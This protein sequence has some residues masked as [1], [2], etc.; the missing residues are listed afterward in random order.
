MNA[1]LTSSVRI[2][3]AASPASVLR[4][5]A[6]E[7]REAGHNII[8]LASGNLDFAT[9]EH[10]LDAAHEAALKGDTR[11]TE[12]DG[13][14]ALKEAVRASLARHNGLDYQSDEIIISTGSTQALFNAFL[15]TLVVG[16][17]VV[18][19]APYWAPYLSQL[20][21][22]GGMPVIVPC[23]Q[24]NGF[25]LRPQDLRESIG[26][27][28][29]WVIINNPVNPSGAVYSQEDLAGLADVL[30]RHPHIR[31]AANNLY[32]HIV[33]EGG[34]PPG[35][36]KVAPHLKARIL[37]VGGVAKA[38]AMMGWRVGY[39]AGEKGLIRQ[40]ANIQSQTTSAPSSISQAAAVA[41]LNGPQ[42]LLSERVE[43][44]RAKRDLLVQALEDC[45]GLSC[46][47]PRGTFYLLIDCAGVIGKRPANGAEIKTDR[48][49]AS[50]LLEAA[51]LVVFPGA[52][53]GLSPYIRVSFA[54]P[55]STLEEAA[56]RIKLACS[57][58]R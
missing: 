50:Y 33:F 38:Y 18:V 5:R 13:T 43:I 1:P 45:V 22:A 27:R 11:Y 23:Y 56:Q 9:P 20:R 48:D 44:L 57:A 25:K 39:A 52:D 54:N 51:D 41:A 31:I 19:P 10:V 17:E 21:I 26:E 36:A 24:N 40:M 37:T 34:R 53:F 35:L 4:R 2:E 14:P 32:E 55:Q 49:F 7:R 30:S 16:D 8:D 3:I 46:S 29:R 28:T 58:L 12:A 42:H 15:A 6:R 47:A